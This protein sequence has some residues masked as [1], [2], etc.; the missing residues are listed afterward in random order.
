MQYNCILSACF[1]D[2]CKGKDT[3]TQ[4]DHFFSVQENTQRL[5]D[6][7]ER[8]IEFRK[9]AEKHF[10]RK[11]T[12]TQSE[13]EVAAALFQGQSVVAAF[14]LRLQALRR[15]FQRASVSWVFGLRAWGPP[16]IISTEKVVIVVM[17]ECEAGGRLLLVTLVLC[18]CSAGAV[19]QS[20]D[21]QAPH[22]IQSCWFC[23]DN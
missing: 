1:G 18:A 12:W 10:G 16:C 3:F 22:N 21:A 11:H 9:K 19:E 5:K 6:Y 14:V 17:A 13:D 4:R 15:S 20:I 7:E 2:S 23:Q 8:Q